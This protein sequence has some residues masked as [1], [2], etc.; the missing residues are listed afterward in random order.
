MKSYSEVGSNLTK[1]DI[2]EQ[3]RSRQITA[4]E[5]ALIYFNPTRL[6]HEFKLMD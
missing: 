2:A 6:A 4:S 1:L 3:L 5:K